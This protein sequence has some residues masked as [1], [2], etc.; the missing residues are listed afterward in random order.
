MYQER[1][2]QINQ[3]TPLLKQTTDSHVEWSDWWADFGYVTWSYPV[4]WSIFIGQWNNL[5]L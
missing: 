1:D 4:I 5:Y 2:K 3:T